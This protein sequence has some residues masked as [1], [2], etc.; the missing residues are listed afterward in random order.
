MDIKGKVALITGGGSGLGRATA[1]RFV[2]QGIKVVLLDLNEDTARKAVEE[3]GE[4]SAAYSIADVRNDAQ[5]QAAIDLCYERFSGLHIVVNC[6]GLGFAQKVVGKDGPAEMDK[7]EF[8]VGI[9]LFGTFNVTRLACAKMA[10]GEALNEDGERGVV[11]N[12]ASVAAFDGQMGQSSY[13][14]S[15]AGVCGMTLPMARDLARSGIRVCTIAPGI[16]NTPTRSSSRSLAWCSFP[17]GW[18]WHRNLPSWRSTS[19]RTSTST[20]RSFAWTAAF[21]WSRVDQQ[22]CGATP[23]HR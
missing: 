23:P 4:D 21:A 14:A 10:Q 20:A 22:R 5:V 12:T 13:S 1:D 15:K 17:R 3:L 16:F 18:A 8:V 6:A 19:P 7:F 2:A 9:N 11:I